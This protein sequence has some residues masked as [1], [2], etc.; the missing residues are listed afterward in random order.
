MKKFMSLLLT[1]AVVF[2][3]AACG[4]G[5]K[6]NKNKNGNAEKKEDSKKT[7]NR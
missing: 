3:L 7:G 1:L 2:S 5:T 6:D 4:S